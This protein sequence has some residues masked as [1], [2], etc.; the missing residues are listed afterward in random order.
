MFSRYNG[1]R[2]TSK[3]ILLKLALLVVFLCGL[4]CDA[5]SSNG[6]GCGWICRKGMPIRPF[7]RSRSKKFD[8]QPH[9]TSFHIDSMKKCLTFSY[10][11]FSH[12]KSTTDLDADDD[13]NKKFTLTSTEQT[14]QSNDVTN[15]S[16]FSN[17][18]SVLITN[19]AVAIFTVVVFSGAVMQHF[20]SP[21]KAALLSANNMGATTIANSVAINARRTQLPSAT[22]LPL[23]MMTNPFQQFETVGMIPKTYF[24]N[25]ITIYGY[26]ERVIDGDTFRV[27][28]VPGYAMLLPT[29]SI[30]GSTAKV[31]GRRGGIADT[32][33][34]IRLYGIDCPEISKNKNQVTQPFGNEAKEY[35]SKMIDQ[36]LVKITLLRK[37]RYGRAVAMVETVP[38]NILASSKDLSIELARQGFAELYTGGGFEYNVSLLL[39]SY[40]MMYLTTMQTLLISHSSSIL[41]FFNTVCRIKKMI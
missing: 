35:T 8:G 40:R 7:D 28:H 39:Y 16:F 3:L 1:K 5:K 20:D 33:L 13:N 37:D 14:T 30:E 36:Q 19:V 24:D 12:D 29:N 22:Q 25:H 41:C 34:L 26:T 15:R 18:W 6:A 4:V 31:K 21:P 23:M 32:T 11:I 27:R 38:P 9:F 2:S 17:I 10:S